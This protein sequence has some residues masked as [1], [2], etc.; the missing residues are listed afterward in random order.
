MHLKH[1]QELEYG[2]PE[3]CRNQEQLLNTSCP[4]GKEDHHNMV[5]NASEPKSKTLQLGH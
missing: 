3:G 4:P 2:T 1:Y 5:V